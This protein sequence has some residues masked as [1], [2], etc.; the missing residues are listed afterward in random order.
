M[1]NYDVIIVG[2]GPA[3]IFAAWRLAELS[4]KN[5]LLIDK[6]P[7]IEDRINLSVKDGV[8]P[9]GFGG[10][11]GFSD[12]KLIFSSEIGGSL[13]E[14]VGE[15]KL[16]EYIKK[17]FNIW[18]DFGFKYP[19]IEKFLS[20]D[21]QDIIDNANKN[22]IDIVTYDIIH[23]GSDNLPYLLKDVENNIGNNTSLLM[24]TNVVN[25]E[26]NDDGFIVDCGNEQFSSKYLIVA[27]GRGGSSWV[28]SQLSKIGIFS[29]QNNVDIGV[30]VEL[31]YHAVSHLTDRLYEFKIR[32]ITPTYKDKVRTFCVC[33]GGVVV[34]EKNSDYTLVN[35]FSNARLKTD[36]TNF[37]LL[38]SVKLGPPISLP[39]EFSQNIAKT[40]NILSGG[41]MVQRFGDLLNNRRST[42]LSL[43][44]NSVVPTLKDAV[45]GNLALAYPYR[46]L[47]NI[48]EGL[49]GI[50]KIAEGVIDDDVLLYA[51][52][53]KMYSSRIPVDENMMSSHNG[54]YIC[55]DGAGTTRGIVQASVSGLIAADNI[56][57]KEGEYPDEF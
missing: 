28:N 19:N 24:N 50:S 48:I 43:S 15:Q 40:A 8:I 17:S 4:Y 18:N 57:V 6:G 41:V 46:F 38:S 26:T 9:E 14:F 34:K 37:A 51:P 47:L 12:G 16:D 49:N 33:P 10:A 7:S 42:N 11:G 35:G 56:L 44:R 53:I 22:D 27:P 13:S 54:L 23:V 45:P 5:V 32:Y 2:A 3:G 1:G 21:A 55:G 25:I 36:N 29:L 52:E 39:L 20:I 30:R 31:P